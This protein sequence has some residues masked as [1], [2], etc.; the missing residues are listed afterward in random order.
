MTPYPHTYQYDY[1][2]KVNRMT[3]SELYAVLLVLAV[4]ALGVVGYVQNII[5][6]FGVKEI[7]GEAVLRTIGV[8]MVPVGAVLGWF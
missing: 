5:A 1:K 6:L 3:K 2:R 7:N 4:G 8:F